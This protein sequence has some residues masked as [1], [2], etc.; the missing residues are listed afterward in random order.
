MW[1]DETRRQLIRE[2][3]QSALQ[4]WLA[5]W[6]FQSAAGE[7]EEL[8]AVQPEDLDHFR[9]SENSWI[10]LSSS[11]EM[12]IKHWLFGDDEQLVPNDAVGVQLTRQAARDLL[13]SLIS[14][15]TP[16][17]Q[18]SKVELGCSMLTVAQ[19]GGATSAWY[20][21]RVNGKSITVGFSA[22]LLLYGDQSVRKKSL[23]SRSNAVGGESLN[24]EVKVHLCQVP[25]TQIMSLQPGDV[26]TSAI[27]LNHPLS[28]HVRDNVVLHGH[29]GSAD[30]RK[31]LSLVNLKK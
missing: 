26:I 7:V 14:P 9:A 28:I 15:F 11:S 13:Q 30:T 8:T 29:L 4:H 24:V 10:A 12:V 2:Q 25:L 22:D 3:L 6:S 19:G 21:F 31:A 23:F 1:L 27:K 20:K 17:T 5:N 18:L 16:E